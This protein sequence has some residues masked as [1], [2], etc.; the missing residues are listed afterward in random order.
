MSG[1]TNA[2][3][4]LRSALT[5]SP[6]DCFGGGS[7]RSL[8]L[9]HHQVAHSDAPS[10]S[11]GKMPARNSFEI[12]TFADTPKMTNAMLGGMMGAMMPADAIRPAARA[13]LWPAA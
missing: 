1:S 10:S 8:R 4:A 11:P 7:T 13:L 6:R 3:V 9:T 12:D 2:Q 5:T